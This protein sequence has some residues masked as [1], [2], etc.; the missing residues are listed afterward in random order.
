M[1]EGAAKLLANHFHSLDKMMNAS[2]EEMAEIQGIG[3][4]TAESIKDFFSEAENR[5]VLEKLR[6]AGMP[7]QEATARESAEIDER[8]AGKSFVF[9]GALTKFTRDEAAELVEKR[10]GKIVKSVSKKT[11]FV[12]VGDDPGSKY[13]KALDLGVKIL[14]EEEF[15]AML[16]DA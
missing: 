7:F 8:F 15:T 11:D 2:V 9:T 6:R 13:Q 14:S 4:K 12:V 10:G 16:E 5:R 3:E 1:G